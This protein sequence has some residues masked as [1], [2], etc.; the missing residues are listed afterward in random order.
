MI[1][2]TEEEKGQ[3][4]VEFLDEKISK[5]YLTYKVI[6]LGICGVG[7]TTI[8]GKLTNK[9]DQEYSPTI[10]L[11]V[12]N[13]KIKVN[14]TIMQIQ[15]WDPCGNDEFAQNLPNLFKNTSLAI[16][17]YAINNEKSFENLNIWMNLVKDNSSIDNIFFLIGNKSDLKN[18][19]KVSKEEVDQYINDYRSDIKLHFET[20]AK[21][22]ENIDKLF[23][24]IS[25]SLYK[26]LKIQEKKI[27]DSL[28]GRISLQKE[29][30]TKNN[31]NRKHNNCCS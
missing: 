24:N 17:V 9:P 12:Q 21:N 23:E 26:K 30:F 1:N 20:S 15:F 10:S 11:D 7:K 18:E 22:G 28:T 4:K 25:I 14:D 29:D 16:L 27:Q 19:R 6:I 3:Y 13:I 31:K 2:N 5:D 8:I